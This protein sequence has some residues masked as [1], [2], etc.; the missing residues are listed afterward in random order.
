M[1]I[2]QQFGRAPQE[3]AAAELGSVTLSGA[4][5]AVLTQGE[6]RGLPLIGPAGLYWRPEVGA[7]AAVLGGGVQ[8]IV[9]CVQSPPPEL[10]PGELLLQ[11]G[12][13]SIRLK[14]DG[15]VALTGTVTVNGTALGGTQT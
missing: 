5:G 8:G 2:S 14:R 7:R 9:G 3:E 4:E 13:G 1:W 6:R 10:E 15:T 11:C 12:G